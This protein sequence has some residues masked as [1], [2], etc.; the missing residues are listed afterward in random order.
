[1]QHRLARGIAF[2]DG[3]A[4]IVIAVF[5]RAFEYFQGCCRSGRSNCQN[6]P[7]AVF[8]APFFDERH[9]I[10]R[11]PQALVANRQVQQFAGGRIERR[12]EN[13]K[14]VSDRYFLPRVASI[15]RFHPEDGRWHIAAP[16]VFARTG[17]HS[18]MN[19]RDVV[20][21][22]LIDQLF[23]AC[24]VLQSSIETRSGK[25]SKGRR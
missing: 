11:P 19:I 17:G 7:L 21:E 4:G 6:D 16:L 12:I 24:V 20:L 13:K 18:I 5:E 15:A 10:V 23:A 2:F 25:A 8:P 14:S 9:M 3:L 22:R 1:L